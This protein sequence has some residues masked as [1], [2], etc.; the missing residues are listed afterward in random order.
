M[1]KEN[2]RLP[3]PKVPLGSGLP[4]WVQGAARSFRTESRF[5]QYTDFEET[6]LFLSQRWGEYGDYLV[7]GLG[8]STFTAKGPGSTPYWGIKIP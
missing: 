3:H 5:V 1:Q 6:L 2:E 7:Q 8:I 4:V